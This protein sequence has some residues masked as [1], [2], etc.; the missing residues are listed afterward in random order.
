MKKINNIIEGI[1]PNVYRCTIK[2]NATIVDTDKGCFVLKEKKGNNV[3]EIYDYLKSRSFEYYPELIKSDD[4]YNVYRYI[5]DIDTPIDQKA[6]DMMYILSLLHNKTTFFKEI[7][8]DESKAIYEDLIEKIEDTNSHYTSLIDEIEKTIYMSPSQYMIARS[9]SEIYGSLY[10]ARMELDKWYELIKDKNKKR[11]VTLY[12]NNDIHH[13]IRN[14]DLYLINWENSKI[15]NPIYDFYNF[16]RNHA[17]DFDF[18]ELLDRY[19]E[20]YPF[21]EEEK[22]LLF[23]MISIPEKII[24]TNNEFQN[25]KNTKNVIDYIYK[26][27][28][29]ILPKKELET[30]E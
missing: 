13:L 2:K 19:E 29:L 22:K 21:L 30:A 26:T 1:T 4:S 25:C 3:K 16:Y 11:I 27:G 28:T 18:E 14:K 6:F 15:E 9:I 17:L 24:F 20:Q 23:I 12:N 5:D 7:D 8:V 10:Y